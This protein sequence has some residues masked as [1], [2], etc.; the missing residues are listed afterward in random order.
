MEA[1]DGTRGAFDDFFGDW[2]VSE[3][4]WRVLDVVRE[5]ADEVDATPAQ[6]SLRWLMEWDEIT[7]IP[8]VG[9]RTPEQLEENVAATEVSLSDEQWDRIMNARYNP[10]GDLWGH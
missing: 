9:A 3:R 6:V 2:Y 5:V 4:G 7:C 8:I 10:E 1:P